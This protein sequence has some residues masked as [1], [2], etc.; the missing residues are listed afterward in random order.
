ML[1]RVEPADIPIGIQ[2]VQR[3]DFNAGEESG[4]CNGLLLDAWWAR[5]SDGGS[6]TFPTSIVSS[7][8]PIKSVNYFASRNGLV[9]IFDGERIKVTKS[10]GQ[11]IRGNCLLVGN[12]PSLTGSLKG[13]FI[14]AFSTVIR[15]NNYVTEGHERDVGRKTDI[16]CC[17]GK[18]ASIPRDNPPNRIINMHGAVNDPSWFNP[19]EIW[20]IPV[21]FYNK[22]RDEIRGMSELPQERRNGLIPSSGLVLMLWLLEQC[23]TPV[24]HYCGF[25]HFERVSNG[26]RHHYWTQTRHTDS[27]EHDGVTEKKIIDMEGSRCVRI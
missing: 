2:S 4:Y 19:A 1:S 16:W 11:L 6:I 14:D 25:D 24:V 18:N 27:L 26:W 17:Y 23:M 3:I 9:P 21:S 12:G 5:L 20:R 13:S 8:R 15:F 7:A 10:S 22:L